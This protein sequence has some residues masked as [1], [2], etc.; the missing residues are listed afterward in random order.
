M[1]FKFAGRERRFSLR[2]SGVEQLRASG[3]VPLGSATAAQDHPLDGSSTLSSPAGTGF[4]LVPEM[5]HRLPVP[6]AAILGSR[7]PET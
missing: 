2:Y 5:A 3:T 4:H 7:D 6:R 1:F